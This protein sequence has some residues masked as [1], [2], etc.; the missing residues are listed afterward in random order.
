MFVQGILFYLKL[1]A[2]SLM[3]T[4]RIHVFDTNFFPKVAAHEFVR[5]QAWT[6]KVRGVSICVH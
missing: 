1:V 6:R 5:L 3:G 2:E 4:L